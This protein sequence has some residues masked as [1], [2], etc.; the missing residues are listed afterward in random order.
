MDQSK[1]EGESG[2]GGRGRGARWSGSRP[3]LLRE[4]NLGE[5][6]GKHAVIVLFS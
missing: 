5:G 4:G 1:D 6:M 2:L 3:W